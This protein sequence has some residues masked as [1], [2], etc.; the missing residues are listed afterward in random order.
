MVRLLENTLLNSPSR[1][2]SLSQTNSETTSERESLSNDKPAGA[3]CWLMRQAG[4]YLPE[5]R[6]LRKE[7]GS[8]LDLCYNPEMAKEV[9]LQ[10]IRRF[11]FDAAILF[12]DILVIPHALGMDVKFVAGEGPVLDRLDPDA[13]N[14]Q[15]RLD[16]LTGQIDNVTSFLAPVCE[17]VSKTRA[18][19]EDDKTLIGFCGAP[20]TVGLYMIDKH[21]SK[22]SEITRKLAFSQPEKYQQLMDTLVESSFHYLSAQVEAG[23]NVLQ[24]FDSW[25]SQVP[26]TLFEVAIEK[27]LLSLCEKLKAKHPNTPIILFPRGLNESKL[28]R[29]A[30]QAKGRFEGMGLD[31]SVDMQW[32]V[33]NLS[34]YVV[35]QGNLD[36]TVMLSNTDRIE[37]EVRKVKEAGAKAKGGYIFNFGHGIIKETPIEH[38]Q[39]LVDTVRES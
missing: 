18:E 1:G 38:V 12:S 26:D 24:I 14:F 35:L 39:K 31:Y 5:Y 17:T 21:P 32:A 7:A 27:P 15:S 2:L 19:L 13:E 28:V 22:S 6:E 3:P 20:W 11:G 10:P 37:A 8:F 29:L 23:A 4:R 33:D 30:K 34:E 16:E 25:A 36:P 9:T